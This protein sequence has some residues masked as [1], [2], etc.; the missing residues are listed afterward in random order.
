MNNFYK[1]QQISIRILKVILIFLFCIVA[2]AGIYLIMSQILMRIPVNRAY[3]SPDEGI[4]I[5]IISNGVHAEFAIPV[6]STV[7]NWKEIFP[8][9]DYQT[10][11][12]Y[13]LFG[14]GDRGFYMNVPTWDDLTF[15]VAIKAILIPTSTIMHVDYFIRKPLVGN[16]S[17]RLLLTDDQYK[18]LVTYIRN[19]FTPDENGNC[20][21]IPNSGYYKTDNFYE[22]KGSYHLFNTCND[23]TNTGLKKMGI[24]TAAWAPFQGGVLYHLQE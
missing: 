13:I 3:E 14:L 10:L 4:E 11:Y 8:D 23:W 17:K 20:I 6:E 9:K 19:S 24:K 15:G 21:V 18:T 1:Y 5:F 2:A 16:Y 12:S 22:A 7:I